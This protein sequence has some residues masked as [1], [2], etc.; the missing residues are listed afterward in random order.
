MWVITK[1]SLY[2]LPCL[3]NP[4]IH[5]IFFLLF[6]EN[7]IKSALVSSSVSY[8]RNCQVARFLIQSDFT[9]ALKWLPRSSKS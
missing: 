9:N 3:I 2:D 1:L 8:F 4:L 5:M 7:P 6:F